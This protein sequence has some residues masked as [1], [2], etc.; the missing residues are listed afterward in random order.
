VVTLFT[1][2]ETTTRVKDT[3]RTFKTVVIDAG[4]G[5]HDL[6]TT[7]RWAG[8]EKNAALDVARRLEPRLRSAGFETVMTRKGDYFIPLGRRTAISNRQDNAIFV[9][10]HFNEGKSRSAQG[11]ETYYRSS[12]SRG[13]AT[14]I[15]QRVSSLPG[16][17]S[18]G[19]KTANFFVLKRNAYPAVLVECGFFSNPAEGARCATPRYREMLAA[20]IAEGIFDQRGILISSPP[21]PT[22]TAATR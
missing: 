15:Q 6:G 13:I 20:A 11:A 19:V 10:I 22:A 12:V 14:K 1:G 21:P 5:G 2:C 9:S 7:S 3:S 4:H 8:Q 16:T 17:A 18:R